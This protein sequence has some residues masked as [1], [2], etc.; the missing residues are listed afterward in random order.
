MKI[1]VSFLFFVFCADAVWATCA[2][3]DHTLK[4]GGSPTYDEYLYPD[5]SY[6]EMRQEGD[7]VRAYL[8][9]YNACEVGDIVRL[10]NATIGAGATNVDSVYKCEKS[11][12]GR[13]NYHWVASAIESV[14]TANKNRF[15]YDTRLN[16]WVYGNRYCAEIDEVNQISQVFEIDNRTIINNITPNYDIDVT[17]VYNVTVKKIDV[18]K[19][20]D[21][22][23]LEKIKSLINKSEAEIRQDLKRY[24]VQLQELTKNVQA[25]ERLFNEIEVSVDV[26]LSDMRESLQEIETEQEIVE[27]LIKKLENA[28]LSKKAAE[29][30]KKQIKQAVKE[31][32]VD[33]S[34]LDKRVDSLEDY[35]DRFDRRLD[36][37]IADIEKVAEDKKQQL[38]SI[39]TEIKNQ[40]NTTKQLEQLI[41]EVQRAGLNNRQMREVKELIN[42]A[43]REMR[44]D[45]N[46]IEGR[47][48]KLESRVSELNR[49]LW[50]QELINNFENERQDSEIKKL[51]K[52]LKNIQSQVKEKMDE[53]QVLD[54]IL[55]EIE[56]AELNQNQLS[57]VKSMIKESA[58]KA[59]ARMDVI[60]KKLSEFD[61]RLRQTEV[62]V[63]VLKLQLEILS[64]ATDYR[65]ADALKND[66]RLK[67]AIEKLDINLKDVASNL[68]NKITVQQARDMIQKA[69]DDSMMELDGTISNVID[70][71]YNL[72][73]DEMNQKISGIVGKIENRLNQI[74][75][76]VKLLQEKSDQLVREIGVLSGLTQKEILLL[77]NQVST[78]TTAAEVVKLITENTSS[79]RDDVKEQIAKLVVEYA[80]NFTSMQRLEI[81]GIVEVYIKARIERIDSDLQKVREQNVAREKINS[82]MSVL[83]SFAASAKVSVWKNKEGNFNTARLASDAVAGVVLGTAGGLISNHII[84]KN[85][86]KGGLEDIRCVVGGQIVADYGDE[87]M[88]GMQ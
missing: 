46:V 69:V 88:V 13:E 49:K 55:S 50:I 22:N 62:D 18:K 2:L 53:E 41:E 6:S 74:E 17:E 54:L 86:V 36:A 14:C 37:L 87:F 52:R 3:T 61:V 56:S 7:T 31:L 44:A 11:V 68:E 16:L 58:R 59:N 21:K 8:C 81:E 26:N 47:L 73:I 33:V 70:S 64:W 29:Q 4:Q 71:V 75:K 1:L 40:K 84:K 79:L 12:G 30:V 76:D 15:K 28:G 85:Q 34:S 24:G 82:A 27:N 9:G 45:V 57:A 20:L 80:K 77:K 48:N 32:N 23:D 19:K 65:I 60:S 63:D 42:A 72:I 38:K 67:R 5:G 66:V 51:A 43:M 83:N 78:K 10:N 35:A 39:R 25:L